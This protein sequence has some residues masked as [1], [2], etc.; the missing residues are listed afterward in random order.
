M[1]K[2]MMVVRKE[3]HAEGVVL[4]GYN[5]DFHVIAGVKT[6]VKVGS[7]IEYK[8]GGVNFG[9]FR[10]VIPDSEYTRPCDRC[11]TTKKKRLRCSVVM[12]EGTSRADA[13]FVENGVCYGYTYYYC[14]PCIKKDER[15]LKVWKD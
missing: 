4:Y 7:K 3:R 13:E 11:R 6:K 5:P 15:E 8:E 1:K 2:E 9:W 12:K 14:R 10:R